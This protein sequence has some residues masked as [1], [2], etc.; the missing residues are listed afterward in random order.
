MAKYERIAADLRQQIAD[1]TLAPGARLNAETELAD[2]YDVSVPTI[3]QALNML[4][5]EGLIDTQHG[6]GRFVRAPRQRVR[7]TPERYQWEKARVQLPDDERVGTGA[8]EQDTGLTYQDL[9]FHAEYH[10]VPAD[11][12]LARDFDI[13]PGTQMLERIYRTTSRD[14]SAAISLVRSYLVHDVAAM[15][16][17]LLDASNEPWPG[18]TQHQLK[19]IGIELD[20]ITDEITARPP[21][22]D[23]AEQLGIDAQGVAVFVLKKTSVGTNGN[24]AELSYVILPGDRTEFAYTTTLDRW[25]N[26]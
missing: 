24:V 14:E 19:T 26:A 20:H 13:E 6:K 11:D 15:N 2:E 18:G 9:K 1:G 4:R 8:T 5:A 10:T 21:L 25:E 22:A 17:A 3:R 7:R 16:P 23:E 12:Q